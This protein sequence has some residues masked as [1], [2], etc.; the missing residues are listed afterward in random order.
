MCHQGRPSLKPIIK[1]VPL[2]RASV[3]SLQ[4]VTDSNYFLRHH[5][6]CIIW[7]RL[8]NTYHSSY[9]LAHLP[10]PLLFVSRVCFHFR[11]TS[12]LPVPLPSAN[13]QGN[14]VGPGR[15][16]RGG[17]R[18]SEDKISRRG[19]DPA[20]SGLLLQIAFVPFPSLSDT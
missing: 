15:Q 2:S 14:S 12:S 16:S 11:A 10:C 13:K 19:G 5:Y 3:I 6:V 7:H 8:H 18:G 1:S 9:L 4:G 17:C 20:L